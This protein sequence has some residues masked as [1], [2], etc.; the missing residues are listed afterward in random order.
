MPYN[1]DLQ[2][3]MSALI[4][5]HTHLHKNEY[6]EATASYQSAKTAFADVVKYPEASDA[7]NR[8][9][10]IADNMSALYR[11]LAISLNAEG[12]FTESLKVL[13]DALT[14]TVAI[15]KADELKGHIYHNYGATL[16]KTAK[17]SL[18]T[19]PKDAFTA[20]QKILDEAEI[21][22][23]TTK[24]QA[25]SI[26][27]QAKCTDDSLDTTAY[28]DTM[29]AAISAIP[30]IELPALSGTVKYVSSHLAVSYLA[31]HNT[32]T[33]NILLAPK[34]YLTIDDLRSHVL[35]IRDEKIKVDALI[36]LTQ[37][38]GDADNSGLILGDIAIAH[39]HQDLYEQALL[40]NVTADALL[41]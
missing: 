18:A 21:K 1:N 24:I 9:K 10:H 3:A 12:R 6:S 20:A 39:G 2:K 32:A 13:T 11:N 25:C 19:K 41:A 29:K 7:G 36:D 38:C 5:G 35:A 23:T 14:D 4:K 15:D 22:D 28:L 8:H 16:L 26:M 34:Y 33:V 40:G 31:S 27:W 17:D 30:D 37:H